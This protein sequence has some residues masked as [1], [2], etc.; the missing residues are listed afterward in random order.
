MLRLMKY[1]KPYILLIIAAVGLLFAQA[2]LELA[3]PDYLSNI[4]DT[5]IQQGGIENAVPIAIR[6]SELDRIFIFL[7][8][9]NQTNVLEN[10]TLED[11]NSTD[12]DELVE[13]YPVLVNESI[14]VLNNLKNAEIEDLE[15]LLIKPL[16][17]VFT[18]E[19]AL[20]NPENATQILEPL[21]FN[22]STLPSPEIFFAFLSSLP[23]ANISF[24][25]ETI[26]YSFES[27][28]ETMLNQLAVVAVGMEYEI[29][30]I[31]TDRIQTM[32]VLKSG[33]LMLLMTLLAVI[34]TIAVSYLASKT[35]AG[36]ARDIRSKLFKKVESFSSV[37]FDS[38]ST[39]SLITRS[40]NDVT[41]VQGAIY[42]IV[43]MV[44]YAPILGIGGIIRA[45][46]KSR[47]MWWI[48]G[49]AVATLIVLIG[50]V[51]AFTLPKFKIMQKLTDRLNLVAREKLTGMLVIRA[52]N[53]EKHEE[54]RF[55]KANIDLTAVSLFVIRVFVI[56]MPF[57][58]L[59]MNGL[60]VGIIWIGAH[61]VAELSMQVGDM[62][63]FLQ[64]SM[65]IVMAFLM[66]TMMFIMIPRAFVAGNRIQEVLATEPVISDP[67]EP[68]KFSEP[69]KGKIEFRDVTFNYPG[70]KKSVLQN[71]SFTSEPGQTTAFIGATGSG[72][73]TVINLLPRFYE[74]SE[75]A[76]LVDGVDI[77][78]V[79]QHDLREV[80]GFIPQKS[81]L[82]SGTI[83]S[84]LR[85]A[86]EDASDE[87][88]QSSL[89]ISQAA[90]FV[91]SKEEGLDSEIAQGGMN[92][93]GGQ[94]QRLSI[95]RAMVKKPPIYIFDDSFSQLDFKTD[96][97]LRK[98]L[99]KQ[100]GD[101]TLLIVT[102]RVSSVK[103]AEQIIVLDDGKI[104]CKGTHDELLE[105]CEIYREIATSQLELEER[106]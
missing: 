68:K 65:Q 69:F 55:D 61:K 46:A 85:F 98:A 74:V 91:S 43:R 73:S 70:A 96:A 90:E 3:L 95:A 47:E 6:Q 44:A 4:V 101:S 82:F 62:M 22:A 20:A 35:S 67:E 105:T 72:K 84:N 48:I 36:M 49:V 16:V 58:M 76:I 1:A 78:E 77:R 97:A 14:Y 9:E 13:T 19:Q 51:F 99:K 87:A 89:D 18:F 92:V 81:F 7:D 102:Q 26:V 38:F 30:G 39:A 8:P 12:Y 24:I 64:Y 40:T 83:E 34:C 93:S 57:M 33:G 66:L 71:I 63:A 10:Y 45:L 31:D 56:M 54:A 53:K 25:I 32:F 21:G 23:P 103:N 11:E 104:V 52:F 106:S 2:N 94:K 5:G 80:I 17:V 37:E 41:Q 42:M 79:T 50:V 100:T 28:G 27:L 88:I 60:A 29:I 75:G 59:I 15:E 86:D